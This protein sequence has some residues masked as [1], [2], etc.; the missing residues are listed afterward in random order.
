MIFAI[1]MIAAAVTATILVGVLTSGLWGALAFGVLVVV[2]Y[3]AMTPHGGTA[4]PMKRDQ[5]NAFQRPLADD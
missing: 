4:R 5:L 3:R 2:T 1:L